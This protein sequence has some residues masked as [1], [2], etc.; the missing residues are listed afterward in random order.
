MCLS[1]LIVFWGCLFRHAKA[2]RDHTMASAELKLHISIILLWINLK[3]FLNKSAPFK[4]PDEE[5]G[6]NSLSATVYTTFSFSFFSWNYN[7][8][9]YGKIVYPCARRSSSLKFSV[10]IKVFLVFVLIVWRLPGNSIKLEI[11][12]YFVIILRIKYQIFIIM[13]MFKSPRFW[14]LLCIFPE[15]R[16][17]RQHWSAQ[18]VECVFGSREFTQHTNTLIIRITRGVWVARCVCVCV[19]KWIRVGWQVRLPTTHSH[20]RVDVSR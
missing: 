16:S 13:F 3:K 15:R 20:T 10:Y 17:K 6:R 19:I 14:L 2:P 9:I 12:L 7:T 5:N 1:Q 8:D 4:N 18:C 11:W